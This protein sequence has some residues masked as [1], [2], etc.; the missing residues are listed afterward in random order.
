MCPQQVEGGEAHDP[1]GASQLV[2]T[3]RLL[4]PR[5]AGHEEDLDEQQRR[6]HEAAE[7]SGRVEGARQGPRVL[8]AAPGN[9]DGDDEEQNSPEGGD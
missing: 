5:D 2:L 7:P 4:E 3:P 1:M 6:G 9:P 8:D